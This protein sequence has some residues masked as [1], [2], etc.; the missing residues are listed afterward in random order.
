MQKLL[1]F[2]AHK[3]L[4]PT[5]PEATKLPQLVLAVPPTTAPVERSFSAL[6]RIKTYSQNRTEQGR[7]SSL[8]VISIETERLLKL[9]E[10]KEDIFDFIIR[11]CERAGLRE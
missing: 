10:D 7:L 3:G 4:I 5:G 8:A 6:K 2:L 11:I 9:K 1:C